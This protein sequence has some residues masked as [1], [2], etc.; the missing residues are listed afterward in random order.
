MGKYDYIAR[1]IMIEKVTNMEADFTYC[2]R[3]HWNK[4]LQKIKNH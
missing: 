1:K 3:I 2:N 4:T